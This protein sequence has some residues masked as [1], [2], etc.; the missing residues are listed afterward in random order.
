M[1]YP[2]KRVY[3]EGETIATMK[4][5]KYQILQLEYIYSLATSRKLMN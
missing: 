3:T 5:L 1:R 2:L 4:V